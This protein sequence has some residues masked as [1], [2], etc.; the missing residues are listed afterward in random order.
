M[1][2][3][4][5]PTLVTTVRLLQGTLSCNW[6]K[7]AQSL[8]ISPKHSE[9]VT[10]ISFPAH[11][12]TQLQRLVSVKIILV[13]TTWTLSSSNDLNHAFK[14]IFRHT[15]G[16]SVM[17]QDFVGSPPCYTCVA[18][19]VRQA[20]FTWQRSANCNKPWSPLHCGKFFPLCHGTGQLQQWTCGS[21]VG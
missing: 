5:Y 20:N 6:S 19:R 9:V 14:S 13:P 18:W 3:R 21:K 15:A 2:N 16:L 10:S 4:S 17:R 7:R 12:M 8:A 1:A 11:L